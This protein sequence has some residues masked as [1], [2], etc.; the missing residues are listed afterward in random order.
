MDLW[1]IPES[2]NQHA[3]VRR[4]GEITHVLEQARAWCFILTIVPEAEN[5][6][7]I[8]RLDVSRVWLG[9]KSDRH[10]FLLLGREW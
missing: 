9:P 2:W 3:G 4:D 7:K 8:A 5:S 10:K 1:R 6:H